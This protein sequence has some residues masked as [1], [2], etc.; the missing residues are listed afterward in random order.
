MEEE[1]LSE[2]AVKYVKYVREKSLLGTAVKYAK[3]DKIR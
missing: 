3:Y 2:T 1:I